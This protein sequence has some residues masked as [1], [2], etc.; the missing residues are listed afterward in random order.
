LSL[1]CIPHERAGK[2]CELKG[3]EERE[4]EQG[5]KGGREEEEVELRTEGM[6]VFEL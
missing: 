1:L 2:E 6:L 3:E 4:R 5:E